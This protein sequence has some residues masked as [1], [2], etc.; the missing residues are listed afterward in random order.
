[1]SNLRASIAGLVVVISIPGVSWA[2][3]LPPS[4][5]PD[6]P[7]TLGSRQACVANC[8]SVDRDCRAQCGED[9]TRAR[10]E[11]FDLANAPLSEC[12]EA[13]RSGL[14]LCRQ[15]CAKGPDD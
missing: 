15:T 2:Q 8:E 14:K 9:T 3:S 12:L 7:A 1:M 5:N 13:C 4:V 11:H 6:N 10:E